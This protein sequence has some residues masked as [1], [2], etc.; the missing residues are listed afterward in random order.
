M[1]VCCRAR[2]ASRK[3]R[4]WAIHG[5]LDTSN[6]VP[7]AVASSHRLA[8]SGM[9][10]I[11]AKLA[12]WLLASQG[13]ALEN[14]DLGITAN[15]ILPSTMDTEANRNA[16]PKADPSKWVQ[17]ERVAALAVFLVSGSGAQ[18]N[19]T[20]IPLYTGKMPRPCPQ[21]GQRPDWLPLAHWQSAIANH[22]CG[23]AIRE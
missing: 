4:L 20:A 7:T 15:V 1:T 9:V 11:P 17:P 10:G 12:G 23:P 2:R 14:K 5:D 19:G 21:L 3:R 13:A 16:Y 22:S 8:G 6:A 18:I